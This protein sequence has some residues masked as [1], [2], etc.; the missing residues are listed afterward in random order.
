MDCWQCIIRS[1]SVKAPHPRRAG[2]PAEEH[3]HGFAPLPRCAPKHAGTQL[4]AA[5]VLVAELQQRIGATK[6]QNFLKKFANVVTLVEEAAPRDMAR[7]PKGQGSSL[8]P[9]QA[10]RGCKAARMVG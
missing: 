5:G 9:E 8:P 1:P 6:T 10:L 2:V 4:E 3:K 7:P